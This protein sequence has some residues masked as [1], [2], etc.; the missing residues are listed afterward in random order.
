MHT[1]TRVPTP[2]THNLPSP[3]PLS[4]D[5]DEITEERAQKEATAN[6]GPDTDTAPNNTAPSSPFNRENIASSQPL[7]AKAAAAGLADPRIVGKMKEEIP[8]PL[9]ASAPP[10]FHDNGDYFRDGILIRQPSRPNSSFLSALPRLPQ[11][12]KALEPYHRDTYG[13]EQSIRE[14]SGFINRPYAGVGLL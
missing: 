14:F 2:L 10:S 1:S 5:P 4:D 8:E 13:G 11:R 9:S 12:P 6:G 3:S 7:L